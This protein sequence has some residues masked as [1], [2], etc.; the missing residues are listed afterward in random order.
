M[1]SNGIPSS[2]LMS[3]L[4]KVSPR[5]GMRPHLSNQKKAKEPE[6]IPCTVA[7]AA[8]YSAKVEHW[9]V[10]TTTL[11]ADKDH[12]SDEMAS[13]CQPQKVMT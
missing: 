12:E 11:L 5:A 8:R 9:S 10:I 3:S 13:E 2:Q 6:K 7:K 4:E 1:V